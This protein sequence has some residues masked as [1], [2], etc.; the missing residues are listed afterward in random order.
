MRDKKAT[1]NDDEPGDT[2]YPILWEKMV[3]KQLINNTQ[4]TGGWSSVFV[5]VAMIALKKKP[6]ATKCS[7]HRTLSLIA[8]TAKMAEMIL[9]RRTRRK[10]EDILEEDQFGFRRR[11]ETEDANEILK[12]MPE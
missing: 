5:Q 4:K 9:R 1:G 6:K 10:V 12:I 7:D 11:I 3:S 8:H 2:V